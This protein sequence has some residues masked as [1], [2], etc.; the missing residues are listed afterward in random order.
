MADAAAQ[1]Y[2]QFYTCWCSCIREVKGQNLSANQ[3]SSTCLNSRLRYNYFRYG[4]TDVR[5]IR[6]LLPVLISVISPQSACHFA[7]GCRSSFKSDHLLRKYDVM[8]IFQDGGRGRS[9]L[10]PA[11]YLLMLFGWYLLAF[12]RS[13]SISK[14]NLK[15]KRPPYW[16]ST[17]GF[18][19]DHFAVIC[20]LFSI[21][22]L[23]FVQIGTPTAE[24]WRHI[25]FSTSIS[26]PNFVDISQLTVEI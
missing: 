12:S 21:R 20:M 23:N 24:I 16:K 4:K 9:I 17:S 8:S 3:I 13:K 2:F 15:N 11:S 26:Q 1:Y 6:I 14:P 5:H 18:D 25:H 19:I 22:L 10:L 7:S